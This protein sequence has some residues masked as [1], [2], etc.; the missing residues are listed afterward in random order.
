[1]A[2]NQPLSCQLD[3]VLLDQ[4]E[5]R[6]IL[7]RGMSTC[8]CLQ[9][10][11]A[12]P[13]GSGATSRP[14]RSVLMC[15][16]RRKRRRILARRATTKARRSCHSYPGQHARGTRRGLARDPGATSVRG[17]DAEESDADRQRDSPCARYRQ[18]HAAPDDPLVVC[19]APLAIRRGHRLLQPVRDPR[20]RRPV[21]SALPHV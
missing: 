17:R 5:V 21:S 19:R 11:M 8:P 9:Y 10:Q 7:L 6:D 13:V 14:F 2:D 1:L 3:D 12:S 20:Q 15:V 18:S 16:A 4:D